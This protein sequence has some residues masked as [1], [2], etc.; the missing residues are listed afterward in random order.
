M[1]AREGSPNSVVG[2]PGWRTGKQRILLKGISKCVNNTRPA[3]DVVFC[4]ASAGQALSGFLIMSLKYS[5][6]S[7]FSFLNFRSFELFV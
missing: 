7:L 2:R 3:P 5:L 4:L 6:G 1:K